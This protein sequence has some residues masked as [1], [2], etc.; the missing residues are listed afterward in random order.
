MDTQGVLAANAAFYRAF[1]EADLL[2]MEA[3]TARRHPVAIIHP[4][5]PAVSGR[6]AVIETWRM[7][8]AGGPQSVRPV[9]PEVFSYGEAALV[10]VYEKAD[11]V[12]LAASTLFVREDGDWRLA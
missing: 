1:A 12:Y 7:I 8:F 3:L 6:G 11:E 9:K 2:A 4:G 10:V 5:W